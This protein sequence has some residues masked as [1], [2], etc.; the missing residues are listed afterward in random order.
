MGFDLAT[1]DV[2]SPEHYERSGYPH[3]EW[4]YLRKH[5]PVFWYERPGFDPFWV[6]S[7]HADI[8]WAGKHPALLWNAPRLAV[9]ANDVPPPTAEE[10][11]HL[12]NMDPP[13]H[14]KYRQVASKRFTPRAV[15]GWEPKVRQ[16]TRE[17]IDAAARREQIDF[18]KDVSAPITIAVIALMLGVPE[19]DWPLLFRWTN[20]VIAPEDPE[21]QRDGDKQKT[22]EGARL[23][24][25]AYFNELAERRR[26]SA[27]ND[28]VSEVANGRV[29]GRA[30]PPV[31]L[32]SYLFLLVVAGN[33][34]TR[35]AMTGGM[36]AFIE[37]PG[38]WKRLQE[39]AALVTPAVEE[40]VRWTT[41]VI[42]FC[43]TATEDLSL[44]GQTIRAGQS[45]CLFY[46]SG[47]RD[48]DIFPDGDVF[49]IDRQPNDHIG[50][51]RGEHVCL[52]AHLARLEIRAVF[53]ELRTR[54][55]RAELAGP[56]DRVRSS[57]VGGIKR[58]PLRWELA[59]A[60]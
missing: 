59:P 17:V 25:F 36:L 14:V 23:E 50:F 57:F 48:E 29:D 54:L 20:E 13:D 22:L 30:L 46:P 3:R 24:V 31:E 49:R 6:V 1:I 39:N 58:A 21:F 32:L 28:I 27:T 7:K 52:G 47:N 53:E 42:Q 43:R 12:L 16:I 35:N 5:A 19:H 51:G 18:V 40:I 56:V 37:N 60:R 45:L 15:Q 44:R 11:R 2:I 55:V 10:S 9:F 33:E 26:R 4:A 34:T 38:E 41:P 8:V